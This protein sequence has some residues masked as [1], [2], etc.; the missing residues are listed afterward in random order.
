MIRSTVECPHEG[1]YDCFK[2]FF[3]K[4][5]TLMT[6]Y[7]YIGLMAFNVKKVVKGIPSSNMLFMWTVVIFYSRNLIKKFLSCLYFSLFLSIIIFLVILV[8]FFGSK[9]F[10][11]CWNQILWNAPILS[12]MLIWWRGNKQKVT[13]LFLFHILFFGN[14]CFFFPK[15]QVY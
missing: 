4:L 6:L 15:I 13:F 14:T 11:R 2:S 8:I 12:D 1:N 7:C 9:L 3:N 5:S 10:I